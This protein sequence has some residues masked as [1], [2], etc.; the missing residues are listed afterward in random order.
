MATVE[1]DDAEWPPSSSLQSRVASSDWGEREEEHARR[2]DE[3][4]WSGLQVSNSSERNGG[5]SGEVDGT[6]GGEEEGLENNMEETEQI[7]AEMDGVEQAEDELNEYQPAREPSDLPLPS[8]SRDEQNNPQ[9]SRSSTADSDDDLIVRSPRSPAPLVLS[10]IRP[11]RL[12]P[13]TSSPPRQPYPSQPPTQSS[14]PAPVI[15]PPPRKRRKVDVDE[16]D[17]EREEPVASTSKLPQKATTVLS[18]SND[19]S[20]DELQLVPVPPPRAAVQASPSNSPSPSR[21]PLPS[22]VPPSPPPPDPIVDVDDQQPQCRSLRTRKPAQLKP[23][24]IEQAAYTKELLANQ[25]EGAVVA[26]PKV[27]AVEL[28]AEE[29]RRKKK[30]REK[31]GDDD[32]DGWLVLED[33]RRVRKEKARG[34]GEEEGGEWS[35]GSEESE[36]ELEGEELLLREEQRKAERELREAFGRSRVKEVRAPNM[37]RG[38]K[39]HARGDGSRS[40]VMRQE[41]ELSGSEEGSMN[42]SEDRPRKVLQP[43]TKLGKKERRMLGRM[44]P[45]AAIKRA[46]RDLKL[47]EME[48]HGGYASGSDYGSGD[49]ERYKSSED[50]DV[51]VLDGKKRGRRVERVEVDIGLSE[52]REL[53]DFGKLEVLE[54]GDSSEE[55]DEAAPRHRTTGGAKKPAGKKARWDA[56]SKF[57]HDFEVPR[58]PVGI[59]FVAGSFVGA[60]HLFSLISSSPSATSVTE[61]PHRLLRPFDLTLDSSMSANECTVVLPNLFDNFFSAISTA[62]DDDISESARLPKVVADSLAFLGFFVTE[63]FEQLLGEEEKG[64][65]VES[66]KAELGRLDVRLDDLGAANEAIVEGLRLHRLALTWFGIDIACRLAQVPGVKVDESELAR[67]ISSLVEFLLKHGLSRTMKTLKGVADPDQD[68]PAPER[69]VDDPSVD[70]WLALI[71]LALSEVAPTFTEATLWKV[72]GE[73]VEKSLTSVAKRTPVGGEVASYS[74]FALC[75]TSQFTP[76]GISTSSPRLSANWDV[77]LRALEPIHLDVLAKAES[78]LPDAALNRLDGYIWTLFARCLVL[79]NRWNWG[80]QADDKL[81]PKLFA[82][83]KTRHLAHLSIE[84]TIDFP[85]ILQDLDRFRETTLDLEKDT[86]FSI[87]L[88]LLIKTSDDITA[89]LSTEKEKDR[90]LSRL[91]TRLAPM[92]QKPWTRDSQELSKTTTPLVNHYSLI[93]TFMVLSPSAAAQRLDQCRRLISFTDVEDVSRKACVRSILYF[94]IVYQRNGVSITP[95]VDWLA[96]VATQIR[97]EWLEL[98]KQIAKDLK[99]GIVSKPKQEAQ[100]RLAVLNLMVLRS[101]QIALKKHAAGA[102]PGPFP[103]IELLHPAWTIDILSSPLAL[104][105]LVGSE[106]C[107]TINC[108]LDVR[109]DAFPKLQATQGE[110]QDEFGQFEMDWTDPAFDGLLGAPTSDLGIKDTAFVSNLANG[111]APAMF[112]LFSR[113]YSAVAE[114]GGYRRDPLPYVEKIVGTWTRC[115]LLI[116]EHGIQD[117]SNYLHYGKESWRRLP[118]NQS[119]REVGLHFA[120]Q[121]VQDAPDIYVKHA[122]EIHE[123]WF[124]SIVARE[125]TAQHTLMSLLL[126]AKDVSPIFRELPFEKDL[127]AYDIRLEHLRTRRVAVLTRVF[128]NVDRY[129]LAPVTEPPSLTKGTLMNQIRAMVASMSDNLNCIPSADETSRNAYASFCRAVLVGLQSCTAVT[130]VNVPAI[131]SLA[132]AA[133]L[134]K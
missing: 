6:A 47:M 67:R 21:S 56:F 76:S 59:Q 85:V 65:L 118:T 33:G 125:L 103:D 88:K 90:V 102:S 84:T 61:P 17:E 26:A 46:E 117:W 64:A 89:H 128:K 31:R 75:A 73:G 99:E 81:L 104:D 42:G 77:I 86:A 37:P 60:G 116:V 1:V 108:L 35:A 58:L 95:V 78:S 74:A 122:E 55:E 121:I 41:V 79:V 132:A 7:H 53:F 40:G 39:A 15:A 34:R 105:S 133:A 3:R 51:V 44:M 123:M 69:K 114:P 52:D 68:L 50:D 70:A 13:S 94:L 16:D 106:V 30:D 72:V 107:T 19:E 4:Y 63:R 11:L 113:I 49:D 66:I 98:E 20:D 2:L 119:R 96:T 112:Q 110:S 126:N 43:L 120:I 23:Y 18:D 14:S 5:T 54:I 87:F 10:P 82:I 134:L 115:V 127:D 80:F 28:S 71:S 62:L 22:S 93:L 130:E 24:S 36:E 101:V 97:Q 29:L 12:S 92:T 109:L 32:L 91:F 38:G 25:W 45:G 48:K 8:Q 27:K 83:L 100:R 131:K 129:L 124:Q 111:V 57:S 9:D